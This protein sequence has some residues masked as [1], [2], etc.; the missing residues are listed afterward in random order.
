MCSFFTCW[1]CCKKKKKKETAPY[2][3]TKVEFINNKHAVTKKKNMIS[4]PP[5]S[6]EEQ[7]LTPKGRTKKIP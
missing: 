2:T 3:I 6:Q 5:N 1:P 7:P 4:D